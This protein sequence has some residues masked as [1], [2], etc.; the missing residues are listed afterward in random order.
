MYL[1]KKTHIL[2]FS[3]HTTRFNILQRAPVLE[4]SAWSLSLDCF[5]VMHICPDKLTLVALDVDG[6]C[7]LLVQ[8]WMTR[9]VIGAS[10]TLF[11]FRIFFCG[12]LQKTNFDLPKCKQNSLIFCGIHSCYDS[13][14]L[15]RQ[16]VQTCRRNFFTAGLG[17]HSFQHWTT[18][19]KAIIFANFT[20]FRLYSIK[21]TA[22]LERFEKEMPLKII[23]D[24][25]KHLVCRS[26]VTNILSH[27]IG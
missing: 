26:L 1:S 25:L 9:G 18:V 19:L 8:G 23:F 2:V 11:W 24:I 22:G 12:F 7:I 27:I 4:F 6:V 14:L 13:F 10:S 5:A 17:F 15:G 3:I 16:T 21:F 20:L